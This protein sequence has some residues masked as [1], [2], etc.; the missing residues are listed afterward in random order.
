MK[1]YSRL[2]DAFTPLGK[3]MSS[4]YANE[5]ATMPSRYTEVRVS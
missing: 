3:G 5:N 4:E 1:Y 2:V